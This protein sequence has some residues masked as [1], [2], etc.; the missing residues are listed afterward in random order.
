MKRGEVSLVHLYLPSVSA[1]SVRELLFAPRGMGGWMNNDRV[2]L[3]IPAT[4]QVEIRGETRYGMCYV[5]RLEAN[6]AFRRF[7]RNELG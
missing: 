6:I 3:L 4:G 2:S 5:D 1:W 7:S